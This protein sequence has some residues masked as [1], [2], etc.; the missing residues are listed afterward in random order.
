LLALSEFAAVAF[1]EDS[2]VR[3]RSAAYAIRH[4]QMDIAVSGA[5]RGVTR[6]LTLAP[7]AVRRAMFSDCS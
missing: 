1:A 5:A 3:M 6:W 2:F 4:A 7:T